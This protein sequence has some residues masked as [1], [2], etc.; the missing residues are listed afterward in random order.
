MSVAP[1]APKQWCLTKVETVN[2]FENWRQNLIYTLSLDLNFAPFLTDDARWAKKTRSSPLRGFVDDAEG[3]PG[4]RTAQQKVTMLELMLGQI[5]NFC[6][7]ISRNSV[8]KNST[9]IND[10]W[11][12]IRLHYG[13]QSTGGHFIDFAD[14][15]LEADE[16]PEDLYQRL[17]SFA[18][19]NLLHAGGVIT[20]HNTQITDDEELSPTAENF[21]VLTWLQLI[22]PD[23]PKLVKQRYG[24][25]L[26]TR[27]L[28]SIKPEISQ[29][30]SSLLDEINNHENAKVMRTA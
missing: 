17:M 15:K 27:T 6:P 16:R 12:A 1:R 29:A 2:S 7:V 30:L 4:R 22:H 26:R 3:T 20:H 13:F 8:V 23:L 21:I 28:A 5:A 24:T 18:E 9:C 10:I 11:Q 19:D 25:E 14:I